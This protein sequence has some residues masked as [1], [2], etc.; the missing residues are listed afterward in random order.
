[1][2]DTATKFGEADMQRFVSVF[3]QKSMDRWRMKEALLEKEATFEAVI[4]MHGKT[5]RALH[6][7]G[8]E[9]CFLEERPAYHIII[10]RF[11]ERKH[12]ELNVSFLC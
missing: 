11:K 10:R 9:W 7:P 2:S 12:V 3:G 4:Y 6:V 1:M 5:G 8:F